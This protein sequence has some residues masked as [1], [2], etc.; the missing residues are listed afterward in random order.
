MGPDNLHIDRYGRSV[1]GPDNLH[2]DRLPG[3]ADALQV[4]TTL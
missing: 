3:D 1:V 2:V 4:R